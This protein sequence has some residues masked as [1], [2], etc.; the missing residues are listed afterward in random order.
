MR[1]CIC[2]WHRPE[3]DC[4]DVN[5]VRTMR[6]VRRLPFMDRNAHWIAVGCS[7][8]I[9]LTLLLAYWRGASWLLVSVFLTWMLVGSLRS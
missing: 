3:C 5:G 4:E 6:P 8:C 2:K 7:A 9:V 1:Q